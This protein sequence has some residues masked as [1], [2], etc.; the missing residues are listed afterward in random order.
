MRAMKAKPCRILAI[1]TSGRTGSV[2]LADA[3]GR[4][5]ASAG[6]LG[7]Q[8]HASELMP[9]VERLLAEVGWKPDSVTD[10][11]VSIGPGSFTGLR[12]GV[13][14]AR[15]LAWSIGARIVPVPTLECLACS[16]LSLDPPP[17]NLAVVLD[18]KSGR[19]FAAAFRLGE[20]RYVSAIDAYMDTPQ[21][22]LARCPRPL[23]VLGEG[24]PNYR[25][26]ILDSR[27]TILDPG[28]WSAKAENVVRVGTGLAAAGR[29]TPAGDLLPHYIRRP[30]PEEKWQRTHGLA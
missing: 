22:F 6:P 26:V 24:I 16:A 11:F 18:A 7:V 9:A 15:T 29:Y 25:Q 13:S 1:E 20:G 2:A 10:V 4:I 3:C 12:V 23:A 8:A 19:V 17:A 30:D 5:L 21:G 28:L 27:A 14:V